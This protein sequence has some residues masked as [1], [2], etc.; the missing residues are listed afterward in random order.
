MKGSRT[1]SLRTVCGIRVCRPGVARAARV[2]QGM[3][4]LARQTSRPHPADFRLRTFRPILRKQA[5]FRWSLRPVRAQNV[6]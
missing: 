5:E 1:G 3:Q 4:S 6:S 2:M